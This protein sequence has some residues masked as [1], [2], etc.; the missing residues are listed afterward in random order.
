MKAEG[1]GS[2]LSHQPQARERWR[3]WRRLPGELL[4]VLSNGGVLSPMWA[5]GYTTVNA[6][7]DAFARYPYLLG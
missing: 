5:D 2:S 4:A 6:L 3:P 7:W 1:Q